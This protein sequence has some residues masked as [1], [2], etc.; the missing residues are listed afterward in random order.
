VNQENVTFVDDLKHDSADKR[1]DLAQ[2]RTGRATSDTSVSVNSA[3]RTS[4][5]GAKR[6]LSERIKGLLSNLD[7][8]L[9]GD[10]DFHNY[11]GG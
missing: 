7:K 3:V 2:L 1:D 9:E 10:H 4:V 5:P 6:T 11:L 8:A